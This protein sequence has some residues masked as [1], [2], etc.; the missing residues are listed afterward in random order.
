[1]LEIPLGWLQLKR[2]PL[3]FAVALLGV[4]FAVVLI[5]MQLGFREALFASAVRF[6]DA[7]DCDVVLLS[8]ELSYVV[9]PVPFS[10]RRLYQARGVPGVASVTPVYLGVGAW[11]NPDTHVV[12]TIFVIGLD[13]AEHALRL[14]EVNAQRESILREDRV[15][16]DEL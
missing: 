16:F 9:Q 3:R 6:H 5:L 14:P 4:A 1:M 8:D 13:P 11:K 7:M 10:Q 2:Q 12:R 15:L